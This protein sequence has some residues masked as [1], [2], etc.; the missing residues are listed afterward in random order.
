LLRIPCSNRRVRFGR[1]HF[2]GFKNLFPGPWLSVGLPRIGVIAPV[3]VQSAKIV[4]T[5]ADGVKLFYPKF[6]DFCNKLECLSL[7]SQEPTL[8]WST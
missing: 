5:G 8:E 6:T 1:R 7:A 4:P 2:G 3:V